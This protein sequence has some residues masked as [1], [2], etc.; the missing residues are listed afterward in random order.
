MTKIHKHTRKTEDSTNKP[1]DF[2]RQI[3]QPLYQHGNVSQ[4]SQKIQ[5]NKHN[6]RWVFRDFS[7]SKHGCGAW[8]RLVP[9]HTKQYQ[10][11]GTSALALPHSTGAA[12]LGG[13]KFLGEQN[14]GSICGHFRS[15]FNPDRN[16]N[17]SSR[18]MSYMSSTSWEMTVP[19]LFSNEGISHV[20]QDR[21]RECMDTIWNPAKLRYD[22]KSLVDSS[23]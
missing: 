13:L 12:V 18:Y 19:D 11:Y 1:L 10:F 5:P 17:P 16:T 15:R 6:K 9:R 14:P 2:N 3:R 7:T 4:D 21:K 8:Y 22:P 23:I 20:N